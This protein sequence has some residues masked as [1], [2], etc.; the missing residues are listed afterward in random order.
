MTRRPFDPGETGDLGPDMDPT[1]ADLDRYLADTAEYPSPTFADHVMQSVE[2]EPTPRR[3]ALGAVVAFLSTPGGT[4]RVVLLAATAVVAILAVVA[5]GQ[6]GNLLP[7]SNIGTSP[8]PSQ[9]VSPSP[10]PSPSSTP[11]PRATRSPRPTPTASET[12]DASDDGPDAS[13][14]ADPSDD[15]SGPGGGGNDD[16]SGPGSSGDSSGP[17]G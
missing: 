4:G 5:I 14:S 16:N 6:I 2:R 7:P 13:E 1:L 3:G 9:I 17:G 12:A 10:E 11:S 15:H 8:Q